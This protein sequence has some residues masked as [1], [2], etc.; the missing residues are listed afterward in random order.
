MIVVETIAGLL[1]LLVGG[2]ALVRGAVSIAQRLKVSPL[3]IGLILVGF[4]TSMPEFVTSISAAFQGAPGIAVGNVVGSNIA[5]I[6]L[7]LVLT[8][9][10]RPLAVATDA[11]KRDG[12]VLILATAL[13][14]VGILSGSLSLLWGV[15]CLVFLAIYIAYTYQKES[16]TPDASAAMHTAEAEAAPSGPKH[17]AFAVALAIGGIAATI[18]GAQLL[19]SGAKMLASTAGVPDTIIG[20]TI[21]AI[22]TSLPELATCIMAARQGAADVAFGNIVGS[23]IF[24]ILGILGA[25][26]VIHPMTVPAEITFA[27][28]TIM[29][30]AT[31]FLIIFAVT[32]KRIS[33]LEGSCFLAGYIAYIG[34]LISY[35]SLT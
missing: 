24:N 1:L 2:D 35:V 4:G 26:A 31:L 8:A 23:N 25:T 21:V 9:I 3:L 28:I 20:L 34:W 30:T 10:I 22:G 15:T 6:L 13:G 11:L 17:L 29:I 12:A 18:F 5:N 32:G 14:V 27:D 19:V 16:Y 7:I 33:R